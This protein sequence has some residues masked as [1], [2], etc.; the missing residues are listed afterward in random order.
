MK[1]RCFEGASAIHAVGSVDPRRD[2]AVV[3]RVLA[4]L[5]TTDLRIEE[6][7]LAAKSGSEKRVDLVLDVV[8]ERHIARGGDIR[9]PLDA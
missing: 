5:E 7:R 6:A 8:L 1:I 9:R 3:V 2:V 4:D